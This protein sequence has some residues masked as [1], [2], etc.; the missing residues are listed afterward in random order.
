MLSSFDGSIQLP[1]KV[2]IAINGSDYCEFRM[3]E[4]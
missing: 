1:G 3:L 2:V 4:L